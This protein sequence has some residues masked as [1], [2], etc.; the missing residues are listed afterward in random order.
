MP[1]GELQ[2]SVLVECVCSLTSVSM[3]ITLNNS[4]I[5]HRDPMLLTSQGDIPDNRLP[6]GHIKDILLIRSQ[7]AAVLTA[8]GLHT[9]L[10]TQV[11]G[12]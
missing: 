4:N 11:V 3:I 7:P 2:R 9:V 10:E 1:Q 5:N 8:Q 12:C 6:I